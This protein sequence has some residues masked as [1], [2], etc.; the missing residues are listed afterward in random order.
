M[1][2]SRT[3]RGILASLDRIG[4]PRMTWPQDLYS[5]EVT[6]MSEFE[7]LDP[8]SPFHLTDQQRKFADTMAFFVNQAK[9]ERRAEAFLGH[10]YGRLLTK[11]PEY[12]RSSGDFAW[13]QA[14]RKE[15]F[16]L[17]LLQSH[18]LFHIIEPTCDWETILSLSALDYLLVSDVLLA[19]GRELRS[20]L[21]DNYRARLEAIRAPVAAVM[22]VQPWTDDQAMELTDDEYGT[23]EDDQSMEKE[24]TDDEKSGGEDGESME[25]ERTDEE[26]SGDEKSGDE[27]IGNESDKS[28]NEELTDEEGSSDEDAGENEDRSSVGAHVG[29]SPEVIEI[30]DD[31]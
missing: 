15:Y 19:M 27:K 22:A 25:E 5:L 31:E 2:P 8:L 21:M 3:G 13:R 11:W 30:S 26:K 9:R 16:R 1:N 14:Q 24:C 7:R 4:D 12:R 29:S 17:Q 28:M 20:G 23:S 18:R 10:C 6:N